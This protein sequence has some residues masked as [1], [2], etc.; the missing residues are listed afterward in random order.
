MLFKKQLE[1]MT[2]ITADYIDGKH[3]ETTFEQAVIFY[4][5]NC[6]GL[7]KQVKKQ[8]LESYESLATGMQ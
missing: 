8:Y 7:A 1:A 2:A 5:Q 4:N 3:D 6:I